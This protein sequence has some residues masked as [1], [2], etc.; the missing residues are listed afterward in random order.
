MSDAE[1][2]LEATFYAFRKRDQ[3]FVMTKLGVAYYVLA[4]A[5]AAAF[6]ALAWPAL[7]ELAGWYF[8]TIGA[9]SGG[10]EATAPPANV[11]V[12]IAPHY[13]GIIVVSVVLFAMFEA[14]CLRWLVRGEAGGGFLG[15]KFDADTLRILGVYLAWIAYAI[16][17]TLAITIFYALIFALGS[18]GGPAQFIAILIGALS[19][20]GIAALMIWLGVL[21]APAAATTIGRRRFSFL[22]ARKVVGKRFWPLLTAFFLIIVAYLVISTILSTIAQIPMNQAM[23]PVTSAIISGADGEEIARQ[24]QAVLSSPIVLG[25]LAVQML[26]NMIL[27]V[28]YYV[29]MFGANARAFEAAVEAGDIERG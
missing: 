16:V 11:L 29:A 19:P 7:T 9:V 22:A 24:M 12:S 26:A 25:S 20:V 23:L 8:S 1:P 28:V 3:R 6:F 4:V 13:A 27:G 17:L 14:A 18:L 15:L 21:F 5:A 2:K 10:G